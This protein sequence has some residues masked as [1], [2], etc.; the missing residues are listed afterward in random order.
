MNDIKIYS[1]IMKNISKAL[2]FQTNKISFFKLIIN[3]MTLIQHPVHS[4]KYQNLNGPLVML[5][6]IAL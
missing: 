1:V 6:V 2:T 3:P 4:E 5:H